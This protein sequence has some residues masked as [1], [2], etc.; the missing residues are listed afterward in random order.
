M[1]SLYSSA[2]NRDERNELFLSGFNRLIGAILINAI[3]D[4]KKNPDDETLRKWLLLDGVF[5]LDALRILVPDKEW[6]EFIEAGCPGSL[7]IKVIEH[8][9]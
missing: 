9:Q 8:E 7:R 4:Y 5:Y 2:M 1:V 3:K 6:S